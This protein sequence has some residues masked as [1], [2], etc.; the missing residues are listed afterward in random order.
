MKKYIVFT[1]FFMAC[2]CGYTDNSEKSSNPIVENRSTR[3]AADDVPT[4][5]LEDVYPD[6]EP[7]YIGASAGGRYVIRATIRLLNP[8]S[9]DD[10]FVR[11]Y[12]NGEYNEEYDLWVH[13]G[14]SIEYAF[15]LPSGETLIVIEVTD[16]DGIV[17]HFDFLYIA[18]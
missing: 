3:S 5:W 10:T 13:D 16:R 11:I 12:V 14:V 4:V 9:E 15:C 1:A 8:T 2:L 6:R 18:I 17:Y 7:G